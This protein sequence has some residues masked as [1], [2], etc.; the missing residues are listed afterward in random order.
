MERIAPRNHFTRLF[1]V[2]IL[3]SRPAETPNPALTASDT[4]ARLIVSRPETLSKYEGPGGSGILVTGEREGTMELQGKHVAVLVDAGFGRRVVG[5]EGDL[6]LR[7][8]GR[9]GERGGPVRRPGS[10]PRGAGQFGITIE[11]K[12]GKAHVETVVANFREKGGCLHGVY[13]PYDL[14]PLFSS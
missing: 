12:G 10:R 13:V 2:S 7:H 14:P 11:G 4:P 1:A 3:A 9:P 8:Q 5:Q 6:L